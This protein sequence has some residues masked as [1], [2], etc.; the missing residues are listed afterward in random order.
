M[1]RVLE[2][3]ALENNR[4]SVRAGFVRAVLAHSS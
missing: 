4:R 1:V 3:G 2:N